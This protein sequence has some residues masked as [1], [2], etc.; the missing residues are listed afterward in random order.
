MVLESDI[1]C[2]GVECDVHQ[3][4][5]IQVAEGIWMEYVRPACVNLAFYDNA[6][7]IMKR[8]DGGWKRFMCGNPKA[9]DASTLCCKSSKTSDDAWRKELFSGERVTLQIAQQRCSASE[10]LRLC[11]DPYLH[12]RDCFDA[13]QGGCDGYSTFN[14]LA[15]S[16]SLYAKVSTD[17]SVAIVHDHHVKTKTA[18][19]VYR[20]VR[21]DTKS[22]F[23]VDWM[24]TDLE[25]FLSEYAINCQAE[26]CFVGEDDGIC[27]CPVSVEEIAVFN[28]ASEIKSIQHLLDSAPIGALPPTIEGSGLGNIPDAMQF[29]LGPLTDETVFMVVDPNGQVQYR[30]NLRS[31]ALLG[32]KSSPSFA[33][34]NPVSF[35]SIAEYTERDARYETD[36]ALRQYFYHP[37]VAPFLAIRFAQRFG[38]SNPSKSY[39]AAISAAFRTGK[40]EYDSISFGSGQ[41]GC[42]EATFSAVILDREAQSVVL[43]ADPAQ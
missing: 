19:D 11:N 12:W 8:N 20:T 35:W 7:T 30:K 29:P 5:S 14:W 40:Y 22:Y 32:T 23:R 34:R 13:N 31:V 42:L 4:R 18:E 26:G 15:S 6:Q 36:A 16:C 27:Q 9:L 41:Y 43:D 1:E 25:N 2:E 39:V 24:D 3:I 28:D 38:V 17:G 10:G 33:F 21:N 37:N